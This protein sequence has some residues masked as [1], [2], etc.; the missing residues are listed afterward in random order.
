MSVNGLISSMYRALCLVIA[1]IRVRFPV[2]LE[3]FR[4]FFNCLGCP[5]FTGRSSSLSLSPYTEQ[6]NIFPCKPEFIKNNLFEHSYIF[7]RQLKIHTFFCP[8][9]LQNLIPPRG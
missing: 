8:E 9:E 3:F 6:S 2:M 4:F 5:F 7:Q 1:T